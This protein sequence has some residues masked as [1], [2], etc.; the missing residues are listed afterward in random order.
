[1]RHIEELERRELFSSYDAGPEFSLAA[2]RSGAQA[3]PEVAMRPDGSAYVAVW[4]YNPN[5][6]ADISARIFTIDPATHQSTGGPEFRVNA[7]TRGDQTNP[8]VAIDSSGNF[9]VVWQSAGQ[10]GSGWGVYGRRFT[11][12]GAA[13]SGEFRVN[14]TTAGDQLAPLVGLDD[15]GR[16]S[17]AWK[18]T[19]SGSTA[20]MERGFPAG[21]NG[22]GA[23]AEVLVASAAA[24]LD[25]SRNRTSGETTVVYSSAGGSYYVRF[26]SAN[27]ALEASPVFLCTGAQPSVAYGGDHTIFAWAQS[28]ATGDQDVKAQIFSGDTPVSGVIDVSDP[29]PGYQNNPRITANAGGQFAVTWND[30]DG[31]GTGVFVR[32]FDSAGVAVAAAVQANTVTYEYQQYQSISMDDQGNFV[33]AWQTFVSGAKYGYDAD[34]RYFAFRP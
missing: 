29:A 34:A 25:M 17:V 24:N 15:A 12:G 4:A 21:Y 18:D 10:D 26:D 13:A 32:A 33:L 20:I 14:Q 11:A 27:N 2:D 31:S 5:N 8:A 9:V 30:Q 23:S 16:F 22:S 6:N 19:S 28:V 1:M 7:T 3:Q